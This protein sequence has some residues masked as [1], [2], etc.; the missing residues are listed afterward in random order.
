MGNFNLRVLII[1]AI[2]IL[3]VFFRFYK[4]DVFPPGLY[5]DEATNGNNA[6]EALLTGNFRL[7]Y[8]ENYGREGLFINIQA[9]SIY[10]FGNT[11]FALRVVSA[12]FGSLT[13]FGIYLLAREMFRKDTISFLAPFLLASSFWHINFSRIGFRAI[14]SPFFLVFGFYFLF[15][16]INKL[17]DKKIICF[18]DYIFSGIFLGLGFYTYIAYR[19]MPILLIFVL[20]MTYREFEPHQRKKLLISSF[21][22]LSVIFL[23]SFPLAI[24]FISNPNDFLGRASE[25]S[26]FKNKPKE[27]FLNILKTLFMFI[28]I[29]DFN[30]R[31]NYSGLPIIP[32]TI[33]IPFITALYIISK[34]II[35]QKWQTE[36]PI[37]FLVA[38]FFIMLGANFL[39]PEGS[40]HALRALIVSPAVFLLAA[41]GCEFL[42][43]KF[44]KKL[45]SNL[46]T[47]VVIIFVSLNI[48]LAWYEYFIRWGPHPETKSAF[49]TNYVKQAEFILNLPEQIN[50]YIIAN[51]GGISIRG[52]PA[53]T[54]TIIYL[55]GGWDESRWKTKNVHFIL[56][57]DFERFFPQQNSIIIPMQP[58]AE[59]KNKI[60]EKFNGAI[61]KLYNEDV[62]AFYVK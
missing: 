34:K 27:I 30:W 31:H 54:Q 45:N 26:I 20:F 48:F 9:L 43:E 38:W 4:L 10:I 33:S 24:Y 3:A 36:V 17:K 28:L 22:L 19:F 13:V 46:R 44:I 15:R 32:P 56:V 49:S 47:L 8:P 37:Y 1:S 7:F 55:L 42:W 29:G 16:G 60:L 2:F 53:S 23:I 61:I 21:I 39:S 59:W 40:P 58:T 52:N 12:V 51:G 18:W 50:K 62:V 5:P 41:F 57:E 35:Y 25:V 14:T 6:I 11:P